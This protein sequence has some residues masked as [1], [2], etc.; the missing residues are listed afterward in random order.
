MQA[1]CILRKTERSFSLSRIFLGYWNVSVILT[2]F[3]LISAVTGISSA[4]DGKLE[5]ALLCLMICG[6]CDMFDGKIA[7]ATKRSEDACVFGIQ[8]DSLCDLVSFGVLP[9]V[10]GCAWG[11][12]GWLRTVPALFVLC[13]LIRLAYFNVDEQKRQQ[14]TDEKRQYYEGLP[15]TSSAVGVPLL[16][17]LGRVMHW[18]MSRLMLW[19]Q[20]IM[21][22]LFISRIKVKKI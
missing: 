12:G 19:G 11:I 5:R 4:F 20:G 15:I 1:Y 17:A 21:A 3:E 9:A 7:R 6:L 16:Y 8:I 22:I 10:M 13:G 14:Q 18:R 2:Y